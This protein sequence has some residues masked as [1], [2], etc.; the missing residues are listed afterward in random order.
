MSHIIKDRKVKNMNNSN[1]NIY[2]NQLPLNSNKKTVTGESVIIEGEQMK[3]AVEAKYLG[4]IISASGTC[5][6][7]ISKRLSKAKQRFYGLGRMV[8][9]GKYPLKLKV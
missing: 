1:K 4:T 6:E 3:G 9:K 8:F 5:K 7:E 2:L